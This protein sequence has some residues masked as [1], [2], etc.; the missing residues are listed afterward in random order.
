MRRRV[1]PTLIN[2]G[3]GGSSYLDA[4]PSQ[5]AWAFKRLYSTYLGNCI[6]VI[7][8]SDNT[9]LDI[10]FVDDEIDTASLLSFVGAGDG[11]ITIWYDQSGNLKD[12]IPENTSERP[13]IVQSGVL[14]ADA[15]EP[16][17]F[18]DSNYDKSFRTLNTGLNSTNASMFMLYNSNDVGN[19]MLLGSQVSTVFIGALQNGSTTTSNLNTGTSI[20]AYSNSNLIGTNINRDLAYDSFVVNQDVL[21]SMTNINFSNVSWNQKIK[22][23]HYLENTFTQNNKAKIMVIYNDDQSANRTAIETIIN[24]LYNVY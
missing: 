2:T 16:Y 14:L 13:L 10:G 5:C 18:I 23:F 6:Q 17:T 22:P 12:L 15:G 19:G 7:R 1:T 11:R 4:Y 8:S 3:G 9:T 21:I 24:S 20:I